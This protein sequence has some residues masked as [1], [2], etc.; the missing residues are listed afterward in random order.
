MLKIILYYCCRDVPVETIKALAQDHRN[1]VLSNC[2]ALIF[3]LIGIRYIIEF[4]IK[5]LLNI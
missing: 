2:I 3:G 1:D 4:E 5:F